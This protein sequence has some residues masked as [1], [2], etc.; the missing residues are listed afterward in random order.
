MKRTVTSRERKMTLKYIAAGVLALMALFVAPSSFSSECQSERIALQV[1]GTR[2]PEF[3]DGHA[4]TG[5]LLW[6]DGRARIIVDAGPGTV[7]RFKQAEAKFEDISIL[8]FT[9]FHVDHSSDFPAYVKGG[10]FS[11]RKQDLLV[12]GPSAGDFTTSASQ[13]VQRLFDSK[14]GLYPYLGVYIDPEAQ[15]DYKIRAQTV[16]WSYKDLSIRDVYRGQEFT[17]TAVPVHH[18]PFPAHGYRIESVGCV[19]SFTG[20]MSGRLHAMPDLAQDSD[21]LVAHNAIPE[22][23]TGVP[24]LLHMKPSYI[25]TL[26]DTANVRKVLLTHL[27]RRSINSKDETL[28]LIRRNYQGPVVFPKDLDRFNP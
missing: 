20:D 12:Y 27:M 19:I 2:G 3:L 10:F 26:A 16:D 21:I 14:N 17:I 1:L 22:D 23:A 8:L 5:Y 25:G 7:Q 13:F 6:L 9:H 15:S 11:D 4:S 28:E 18:G 24:Q